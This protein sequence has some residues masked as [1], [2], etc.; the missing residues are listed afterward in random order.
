MAGE[1]KMPTASSI[2]EIVDKYKV[3][4]E[5]GI[6]PPDPA[7][8]IEFALRIPVTV[9]HVTPLPPVLEYVHSN[10]TR[11]MVEALPRLPLTSDFPEYEWLRWIKEEWKM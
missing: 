10:F 5:S 2:R 9:E 1:V 3:K 7:R 11:P 8:I 6:L 4:I